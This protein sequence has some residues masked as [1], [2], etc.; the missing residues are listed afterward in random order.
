LAV[1]FEAGEPVPRTETVERIRRFQTAMRS[2]KV[3]VAL[4]QQNSDLYYLTGTVA[5]GVL[6]VPADGEAVFFVR[7]PFERAKDESAHQ[8]VVRFEKD[9]LAALRRRGVD[10]PAHAA[11]GLELDVVPHA[12]VTRSLR[13]NQVAESSAADIGETLRRVRAIKSTWERKMIRAAASIL[14]QTFADVDNI[15]KEGMREIELKAKI[16]FKMRSLGA[17]GVVLQR[18]FN[19]EPFQGHVLSGESACLPSYQHSAM[20]GPGISRRYP[21]D[22][23]TRKIRRG[24]PVVVDLANAYN[25]YL[26]DE[27]RTF[28]I[29]SLTRELIEDYEYCIQILEHLRAKLVPGADGAALFKLAEEEFGRK[30]LLQ[31]L[32]GMGEDRVAFIGHGIGVELDELPVLA[33]DVPSLIEDGQVVAIEPKVVLPRVGMIGVED[34]HFVTEGGAEVITLAKYDTLG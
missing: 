8:P 25:G 1:E 29:G 28:A 22:A 5:E 17:Q 7:R 20:G 23:G 12:W 27:T 34:T 18:R 19:Q 26:A 32:G 21:Q 4:V 33:K 6:A 24:E 30:G 13:A 9:Q 15:L 2:A 3:D 16:E 31:N 10:L 11:V 14:D